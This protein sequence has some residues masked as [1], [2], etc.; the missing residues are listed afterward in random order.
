[1][2][3]GP[4]AYGQATADRTLLMASTLLRRAIRLPPQGQARDRRRV[5]ALIDD[6]D[7][8][9]TDA[10]DALFLVLAADWAVPARDL[11][12][13]CWA[14]LEHTADDLFACAGQVAG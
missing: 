2:W 9:V 14:T 8:V 10:C 12:W 3:R 11:T 13:S 4:L 7:R 5:T 1:M 6:L